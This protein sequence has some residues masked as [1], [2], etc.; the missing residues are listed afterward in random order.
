MPTLHHEC[1]RV[2]V[3]A[4]VS[5][6]ALLVAAEGPHLRFYH[7]ESSRYIASERVFEAQAVHG[8]SL[9]SIGHDG[10]IKLV[11]WGGSLVRAL[12]VDLVTTAASQLHL[13]VRLSKVARAS[14]WILDLAPRPNNVDNGK[15]QM[16]AMCIAVTAHNALVQ[17]NIDCWTTSTEL[18]ATSPLRLTELT[19]SSRSILYSAHVLCESAHCV[20]VAAGT[21]F[22]EIIYWSWSIEPGLKAK[23][24]IHRIFLGHEGSIFGVRISERLPER[25]DQAL[26]RVVASCSDDRTIRIWDVSDIE[27]NSSHEDYSPQG[28][29]IETERTRHTGF[30]NASFDTNPFSSSECLAIG[31]AHASR[32]WTLRFLKFASSERDLSL[33][34]TGE[35]ASAR[36]W[37]LVENLGTGAQL[38]YKLVEQHCAA[39]HNG[40]NIWASDVLESAAGSSRVVCGA[41]DA[42]IT[43][44]PINHKSKAR[45]LAVSD[46]V[47]LA[48]P[49]HSRQDTDTSQPTHRSSKM[50][51]FFRSYCFL[52]QESFLLTT[53][54]GKVFTGALTS[55]ASSAPSF[56]LSSA[57]FIGQ[58]DDLTGYSVC[59]G[60]PS[61]GVA[62]VAGIRGSIY[63]YTSASGLLSKLTTI[64]GKIGE[65]FTA[66]TI[67]VGGRTIAPLLAT[68]AGKTKA[69]L[70]YVDLSTGCG[71]ELLRAIDVPISEQLTGTLMTS[72]TIAS[73]SDTYYLYAGFRRGSVA[74]YSI[75]GYETEASSNATLLR[76]IEKVHGYET[77]T[78][79]AWR[80]SDENVA[81]GH[82]LSVGRDGTL[83]IHHVNMCI[84]FIEHVHNLALPIGPNI[85]GIYFQENHVLVHGFSNKR[86]VLYDVTSET[87]IMSVETG[88]AHRS[89]AFSPRMSE[90]GGGALIWTRASAMHISS[91]RGPN[92]EVVRPGGHGRE[93]KSVAVSRGASGQLIATGA[94][95]TGIKISEYR[96]GE[97]MCLKTLRK[98][99]TGIQHLQW[100]EN[101]EYL[102]SSGGCEEF[103]IWRVRKLSSGLGVGVVC[104]SIYV[105]ESE[106]SD[107]RIM[108]FDAQNRETGYDLAMVFSDS[109]IKVYRYNCDAAAKWQTLAKG[110]YFTSCLTQCMSFNPESLLT[111]GTDGHAVVW[112][113]PSA[114]STTTISTMSWQQPLQ[115]HQSSSKSMTSC[116]VDASRELVV[117]GG[118]DGSLAIL[119][120][121]RAW[122]VAAPATAHVNVPVLLSRTHAS[123]VTA[124]AVVSQNSSHYVLT[125]GNDQWVRLWQIEISDGDATMK[126]GDSVIKISRAGKTKTNVAD[127]SSMAVLDTKIGEAKVLICG[128][129]MEVMRVK[130]RS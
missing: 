35:D 27:I 51:E 13:E 47:S 117:S 124:C 68:I 53:N 80:E 82:L 96:E 99:T 103:Y 4:L 126:G 81:K 72:I 115:V 30:S 15:D 70:L 3:T 93:I 129:G 33:L 1:T 17:I 122:S 52:N 89:W 62:F 41:A 20:L 2:P 50:A 90:H 63:V 59:I 77:V 54:S 8:A 76:V 100:S 106:Y 108:S 23:S 22:G 121:D 58:L 43:T 104:E 31:W 42:K 29:E 32:V 128:V 79:L 5:C 64:T 67:V 26:Q 118:D 34:S 101:G 28:A 18:H 116:H 65:M 123:A 78:S 83:A 60:E 49:E 37:T 114:G 39:H 119:L 111:I 88:G 84:D 10:L 24:S 127:V 94:E 38:P 6:G 14:D 40:K 57:R 112:P 48:T 12:E 102:F 86:W 85:E 19:S 71:P 56:L 75:P 74:V 36:L 87:E 113:F 11:I 45:E 120:L 7:G 55:D 109:S 16:Q 130:W 46:F 107:L 97:L 125:S 91:Q 73:T 9:Y 110:V 66:G 95:D 61:N 98:H 105:P 44:Y 92:H 21:A 25:R 69:T